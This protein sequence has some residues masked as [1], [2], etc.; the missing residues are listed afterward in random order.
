MGIPRGQA[1]PFR[2]RLVG[3]GTVARGVGPWC[4]DVDSGASGGRSIA[5]DQQAMA[6]M[7]I[8]RESS[9]SGVQTFE[10]LVGQG[11]DRAGG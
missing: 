4:T 8:R 5:L 7:S 1:P 3:L 11:G 9:F 6:W 2:P 10:L